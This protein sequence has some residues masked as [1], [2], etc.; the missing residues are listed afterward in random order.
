MPVEGGRE[1][2]WA[3]IGPRRGAADGASGLQSDP[4]R[5]TGS[6][7]LSRAVGNPFTAERAT[8]RFVKERG[9]LG[10]PAVRRDLRRS[11]T[12]ALVLARHRRMRPHRQLSPPSMWLARR[13]IAQRSQPWLK[14]LWMVGK[15]ACTPAEKPRRRWERWR[16]PITPANRHS[17]HQQRRGAVALS[18]ASRA[19]SP[20]TVDIYDL[21]G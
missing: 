16:D 9:H 2:V 7:R 17:A 14:P 15:A 4:R 18:W 10:L 13:Q 20:A 1:N 11:A 19:Q 6:R 8:I 12:G 5:A 3:R 21:D